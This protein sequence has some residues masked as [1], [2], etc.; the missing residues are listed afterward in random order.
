MFNYNG[1]LQV[2]VTQVIIEKLFKL[3]EML[4]FDAVLD[5]VK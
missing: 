3:L 1:A 4:D 5:S 2:N